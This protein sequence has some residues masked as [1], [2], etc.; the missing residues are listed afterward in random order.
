MAATTDA[1]LLKTAEDW[2]S[3]GEALLPAESARVSGPG[4]DDVVERARRLLD[5]A[6]AHPVRLGAKVGEAI[7]GA[8]R[9]G[10]DAASQASPAIKSELRKLQLGAALFVILPLLVLY[11]IPAYVLTQTRTG[12]RVGRKGAQM[13]AAHYGF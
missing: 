1:E 8:A 2:L 3:R 12:R 7:A 13:L 9:A 11:V 10:L 6:R 5:R 4:W